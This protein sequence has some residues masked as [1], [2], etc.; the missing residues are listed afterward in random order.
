MRTTSDAF[1]ESLERFG[2][3]RTKEVIDLDNKNVS[4][5]DLALLEFFIQCGDV[6]R[7]S[8]KVE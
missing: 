3:G 2:W 4:A 1:V 7:L 8:I 5:D 6:E